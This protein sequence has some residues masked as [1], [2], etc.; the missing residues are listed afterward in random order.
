MS[1][2]TLEKRS[3]R[4]SR[5]VSRKRAHASGGVSRNGHA[6]NLKHPKGLAALQR[7][8]APP[9]PRVVVVDEKH[10]ASVR[11]FEAG[12]R[13]LQR[14]NYHKAREVF[15]KLIATARSDVADRSRML[16]R[17]CVDRLRVTEPS[18]R[19]AGD[20]HVLGVAELNA[21]E[22]DNAVEHLSQAE[23]LQPK[24]EQIRYALAAAHCLKGNTD[25]ALE[26][27]KRAIALR[28]QNRFQARQDPNFHALM[29]DERF[30]ALTAE[31]NARRA[32]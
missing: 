18:P 3:T 31:T 5:N 2:K 11:N 22:L 14:Q 17:V 7:R 25:S 16:L 26:H 24:N 15:E 8:P 29:G 23:K 1:T 4:S 27:L 20:Y 32:S 6:S 28:A 21:R 10:Q 13:F 9:P 19:T 30:R 12:L